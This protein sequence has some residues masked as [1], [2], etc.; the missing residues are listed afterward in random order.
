M[1][2]DLYIGLGAWRSGTG[3]GG[4]NDQAEWSS[5]RNLA[6]MV[7]ALREAGCG[8]FA[9]YRYDSLYSNAEYPDLAASERSALGEFLAQE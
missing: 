1:G 5:G 6:A 2:V 7:A 3:D 8:G 9:L 4:A